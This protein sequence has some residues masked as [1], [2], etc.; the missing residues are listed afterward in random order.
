MREKFLRWL[1]RLILPAY[2]LKKKPI[3]KK[4]DIENPY[5]LHGE[6]LEKALQAKK[7]GR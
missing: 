3:R 6:E 4:K 2:H 5:H 7:E 1:I